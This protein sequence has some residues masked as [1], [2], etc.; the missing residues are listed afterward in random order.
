MLPRTI[1]SIFLG[2]QVKE[3]LLII[4]HDDIEALYNDAKDVRDLYLTGN[5]HVEKCKDFLPFR[6]LQPYY[7][8]HKLDTLIRLFTCH[9]R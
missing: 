3:L 7:S 1:L 5:R 6:I 9:C 2:T 4:L 8:S